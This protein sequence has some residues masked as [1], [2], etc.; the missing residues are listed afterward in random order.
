[1]DEKGEFIHEELVSPK[2]FQVAELPRIHWMEQNVRLL[3]GMLALLLID[4]VMISL[5][6]KGILFL[7]TEVLP[8][9]FPAYINEFNRSSVTPFVLQTLIPLV[10]IGFIAYEGMYTSRLPFWQ[11]AERL[12]KAT[13]FA[14]MVLL[15]LLFMMGEVADKSRLVFVFLWLFV[16]FTVASGRWLGK[17]ILARLGLW[18]KPVLLIGAGQTAEVLVSRFLSDPAI[19]Y[20]VIGI[21]EDQPWAR[22]L[23][24]QVPCLGRFDT[25]VEVVRQTGVRDV[26]VTAPGLGKAE[27]LALLYKLQPYTRRVSFVPDLFGV[28]LSNLEMDTVFHDR[29]LLLHVKNNLAELRNRF[30]KRTIDILAG[31][32]IFLAAL[33]VLGLIALAIRLETPGMPIFAHQRVGRSGREFPCLKFRTMVQNSA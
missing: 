22:P 31:G 8:W 13:F 10:F 21:L 14:F 15:F 32:I 4:Y 16:F 5:A 29:T 26:M 24:R 25:A 11:G 3:L 1:M 2:P 20:K 33:P 18:A 19:G 7:R 17:K 27:L 6:V 30:L 23:C 9:L 28:P 12:F